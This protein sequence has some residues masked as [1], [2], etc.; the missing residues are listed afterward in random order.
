MKP[1]EV[2]IGNYVRYDGRIF[3][4]DTISK[5]FPTLDTIKFGIGVVSWNN[6][7]PVELTK[8][9]IYQIEG[10]LEIRDDIYQIGAFILEPGIMIGWNVVWV[11]YH[12][13][14]RVDVTKLHDFQNLVYV[15]RNE[16][17]KLKTNG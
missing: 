8:E 6:I 14:V 5:E 1:E 10:V 16:T 3:Q 15:L 7:A 9:I 13:T 12:F 2:R 17:I 4:I 11:A